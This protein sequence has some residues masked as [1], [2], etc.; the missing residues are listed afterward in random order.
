ML[1]KCHR[2]LAAARVAIARPRRAP[3][4][5]VRD[6]HEENRSNHQAVQ[7]RRSQRG[8]AGN[9]TSGHHRDR[10][11]GVRPAEGPYRALPRRGIRG[12][13][14]AEGETGSRPRRRDA[15]E[16]LGGHPE[17]RADRSHRRR[18]DLHLERRRSDPH[19]HGRDRLGRDL[20][21]VTRA[22]VPAPILLC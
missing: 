6:R 17:S 7:A 2:T 10:G 20:T 9:R 11:Q 21:S 16:G 18:Q 19:S 22:K 4:R 12:G 8:P 14:P 13:L 5:E 3:G 1:T 15:A